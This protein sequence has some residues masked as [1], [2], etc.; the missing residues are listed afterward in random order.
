MSAIGSNMGRPAMAPASATQAAQGV[1]TDASRRL[2]SPA[3]WQELTAVLEALRPLAAQTAPA[4][5]GEPLPF[6]WN[7]DIGGLREAIGNLSPS[8][9]PGL[10]GEAAIQQLLGQMDALIARLEPQAVS[11]GGSAA[12][13]PSASFSGTDS[14]PVSSGS[15]GSIDDMMAQAEK[16][17]MSDKPSDQLKAQKLMMQARQ[18]FETVS[19]L[20]Q[21]LAEMAKTAISNIR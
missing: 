6:T 4:A 21:Q 20:L 11:P 12:A 9:C 15:W 10:Q 14:L 8:C 18:M 2:Q 19:K 3:Q 1:L 16:L 13:P 17:A 7:G 5:A